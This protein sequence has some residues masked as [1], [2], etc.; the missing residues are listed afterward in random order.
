MPAPPTHAIFFD[1]AGTLFRLR[2]S[3]GQGYAAVAL[4]FGFTIEP[5][6]T[7]SEFRK[8]LKAHPPVSNGNP[9]MDDGKSWWRSLVARLLDNLDPGGQIPAGTRSDYFETLY[10]HYGDPAQWTP[11]PETLEVLETLRRD[12]PGVDL[13]VL[14]NFDGRLHRIL[15]GLGLRPFFKDVIVSTEIGHS[16]PDP[17]IFDAAC[18]RHGLLPEHCLHVGDDPEEDWDGA[19]RAGLRILKLQRPAIDLRALLDL[20]AT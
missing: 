9:P 5:S 20:P 8:Q 6:A 13:L 1:A 19:S 2:E 17:A 18:K 7:E 12:R 3:V 10:A 15:E 4:R 14:S 16:K 11:Y